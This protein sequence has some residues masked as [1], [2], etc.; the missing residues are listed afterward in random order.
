[1]V[2]RAEGGWYKSVESPRE[3]EMVRVM[4]MVGWQSCL[5]LHL[6]CRIR[7]EE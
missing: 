5:Y 1:M 4:V 3:S 6:W 2:H 7:K